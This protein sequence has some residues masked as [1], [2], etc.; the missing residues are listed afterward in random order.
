M[1][2]LDFVKAYQWNYRPKTPMRPAWFT[3]W[4]R[5]ARIAV[6][7]NIMHEWESRPGPHTMGRRPMPRDT[8]Y[9]DDFLALSARAYGANFGIWRLLD[10]LDKHNVKATVITS[11]LTAALFPESVAEAHRR[12]HEIATHHWDQTF[13][14]T[15]YRTT[16][17]ERN[18]ITKSLAAIENATGE[19]PWGYMSPG[20]RPG[21]FTLE[22]CA[23]LGFRWNGDYCDSDIPYT[24]DVNG[25]KLASLGYVR[26]AHSDNDIVP[27]GLACG[28][29]QLKDEFDAHY[30]E[31]QRH[32]MKFR[33][34]M[35]NFTGG[36]PGWAKVFDNFLEYV[37]GFPGVWF[38]R[39][40]DMADYWLEQEL[41]Y[42]RTQGIAHKAA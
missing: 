9:S 21:P 26:P 31:A 25:V 14:P 11:G 18:A 20:P 7:I 3:E 4:P 10:V 19:R 17:E 27:L 28:L 40:I 16:D 13:H 33:Y 2:P 39:C 29:Q 5:G 34:A 36:R 8:V 35:H 1:E 41:L 23:E 32:P 38:A 24:I 15:S 12:G 22:L 30:E 6:T 37:K 42:E